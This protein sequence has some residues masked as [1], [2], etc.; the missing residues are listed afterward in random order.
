VTTGATCDPAR[1]DDAAFSVHSIY[2]M[3]DRLFTLQEVHR[4]LRPGGTV[5]IGCRV[6]DD[7]VPAWHDPAVY[8]ILSVAETLSVLARAGFADGCHY[9]PD[10]GGRDHVFVA[11][12]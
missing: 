9:E 10:A 8:T 6:S 2:Y 4:V 11:T 3:P 1:F 5:A 7:G 12:A